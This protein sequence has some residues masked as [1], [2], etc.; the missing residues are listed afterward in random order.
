MMTRSIPLLCAVLCCALSA[1]AYEFQPLGFES[2]GMGGAGVASA[3]G[4]MA[5]YY[6]PALLAK[7]P[8]TTEF[9]LGAGVGARELNL[10]DNLDRLSQNDPYGALQRVAANAPINGSNA[11]ADR[12][13][14]TDTQ[15]ILVKMGTERNVLSVAPS[16]ALGVQV[17]NIGVGAYLTGDAGAQMIV[18]PTRTALIV[19]RTVGGVDA[20]FAYNPTLDTYT[21]GIDAN[22]YNTTSLEAALT[23]PNPTTYLKL[24]GLAIAEVP[25]SYARRLPLFGPLG[26]IAVGVSVKGMSGVTYRG[27]ARI[28]TESGNVTDTLENQDKR[29]T[30]IGVDAGLLYEPPMLKNITIG[31]VGKNLNSPTFATI[32]GPDM[33]AE[34]MWRAG[35]AISALRK[36]D[37]AADL[38]L[39]KNKRFDGST[40]QYLGGGIN[41]HP[42]GGFSL[43]LGAMQNL[44]NNDE[45]LIGTAG[46]G[47]GLKQ[48]QLDLSAEIASKHGSYQGNTI[49]RY[50]KVNLAIVSR[51]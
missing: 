9:T 35:V 7:S 26:S 18:D 46:L 17:K 51:W 20:Y 15:A 6:N 43:R 45:G 3:K 8:H 41:L 1:W 10:G 30:A 44:S 21:P 16:A 14:L 23:G 12:A 42:T 13:A 39:T 49:P 33:V 19:R 40:A 31:V 11:A 4:A 34:P 38:D 22:T 32:T 37:F 24:D 5:G 47:I 2:I 29:S 48:L 28:D 27:I 25:L 50:G 36:L